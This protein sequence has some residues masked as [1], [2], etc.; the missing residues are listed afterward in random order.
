M[1]RFVLA[2]LIPLAL[3]IAPAQAVERTV[4]LAVD[5]MTCELCPS[6]VRKSLARVPGVVKAEVSAEKA[7][8]VV[9]FDD[10][11]TSIAALVAATTNAGYPSRPAQ[12]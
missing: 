10:A 12:P 3:G 9:M 6:I 11:A 4:T 2:I 1:A 5:N 8:A 7:T